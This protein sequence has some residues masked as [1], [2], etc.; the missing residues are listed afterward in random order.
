MPNRAPNQ[1]L[2]ELEDPPLGAGEAPLPN[3]QK[4][5]L[6][7][8]TLMTATVNIRGHGR[9]PRGMLLLC[10]SKMTGVLLPGVLLPGVEIPG[11]ATPG[12]EIPGVEATNPMVP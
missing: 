7:G 4:D 12:V 9:T 2:E 3:L 1:A 11:V 6:D 8:T 5:Y 10:M